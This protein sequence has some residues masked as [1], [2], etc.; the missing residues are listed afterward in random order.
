MIFLKGF[1]PRVGM[2]YSSHKNFLRGRAQDDQVVY[3]LIQSGVIANRI[4]QESDTNNKKA[5][6][7]ALAGV[8]TLAMDPQIF[9]RLTAEGGGVLSLLCTLRNSIPWAQGMGQSV[10]VQLCQRLVE[11]R[12]GWHDSPHPPF[13]V[14]EHS[15]TA[16]KIDAFLA[17]AGTRWNPVAFAMY[18][19]LDSEQDNVVANGVVD[20][21]AASTSGAEETSN[22]AGF[23]ADATMP[24]M[25]GLLEWAMTEDEGTEEGERM[26][27]D[28]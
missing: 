9:G 19:V 28:N 8:F 4:S 12:Q 1:L 20:P 3:A 23:M 11:A 13:N 6:D 14:A 21:A 27:L 2:V 26:D 16:Q 25:M 7:Q 17:V 24:S 18:S 10:F 22:M 15:T 5:V